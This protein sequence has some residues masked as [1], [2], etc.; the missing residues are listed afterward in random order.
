MFGKNEKEN[1]TPDEMKALKF[2]S[3]EYDRLTE[4]E[5]NNRLNIVISS[6]SPQM[7]R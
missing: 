5:I 6:Q 2:L 7:I 4:T 3:A 1:L